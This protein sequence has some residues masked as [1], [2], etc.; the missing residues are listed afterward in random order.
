MVRGLVTSIE[1][2]RRSFADRHGIYQ[3]D[4]RALVVLH[5]AARDGQVSTA[6][7]LATQLGL[8]SGAVTYLVERLANAGLLARE[9]DP[10]DRRKVLL[11][12]TRAGDK[13]VVE[14]LTP[15]RD[16]IDQIVARLTPEART[17]MLDALTGIDE[18]I[19][20]LAAKNASPRR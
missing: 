3:T 9:V 5:T 2:L 1:H 6:G 7:E 13:L 17:A 10:L 8:S 19:H 4:F 12:P 11:R 18:L 20:G 14:Y 15:L 16:G